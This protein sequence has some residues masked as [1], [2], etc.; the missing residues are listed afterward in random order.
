M[1]TPM[2]TLPLMILVTLV[3]SPASAAENDPMVPDMI[4]Q[5]G[6]VLDNINNADKLSD[7]P[8]PITQT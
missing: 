4:E 7:I 3:S 5:Y 8:D 2:K 6:R 1:N